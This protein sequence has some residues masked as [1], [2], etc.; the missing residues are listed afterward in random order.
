MRGMRNINQNEHYNQA[1]IQKSDG[2]KL[3]G[4]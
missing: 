3:Y 2:D 1:C 4:E